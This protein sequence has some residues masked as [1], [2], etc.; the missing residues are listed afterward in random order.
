M[1]RIFGFLTVAA[2]AG[3]LFAANA[4]AQSSG[5]FNYSGASQSPVACVLNND[6]TGTISGGVPCTLTI[7]GSPCG[8]ALAACP[9]G[10][11]CFNPNNTA[12]SGVC[13]LSTSGAACG[14][15]TGVTCTPPRLASYRAGRP[16]VHVVWFAA[17][18]RA[19]QAEVA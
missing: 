19:A 18:L 3:M 16:R 9:A 11:F 15:T 4:F 2:F 8:T 1:K 6:N 7:G 17:G 5:S 12:S 13:E 14:G 10:Q